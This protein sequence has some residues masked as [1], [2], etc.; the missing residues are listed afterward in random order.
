MWIVSPTCGR[1]SSRTRWACASVGRITLKRTDTATSADERM[2]V[3]A[4]E[5]IRVVAGGELD[6]GGALPRSLRPHG[7]QGTQA[8]SEER[9]HVAR[10]GQHRRVPR[11]ENLRVL[12]QRHLLLHPLERDGW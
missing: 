5:P 1:I 3:I 11:R 7:R 2:C 6:R 8:R 12:A 10:T 4:S 9:F